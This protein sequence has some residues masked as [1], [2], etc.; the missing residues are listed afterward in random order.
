MTAPAPVL[1]RR[2]GLLDAVFIG[3]GSM[4]GAGV[5]AVW[6]PA[7]QA[8]GPLLLVGLAI[9]LVVAFCNAT[10]SAQL[11]AQYPTSG[12]TYVYGRERLGAWPGFIAGWG[13]VVGKTA[14]IAAMALT[15]GAYVFGPL[16]PWI[17]VVI[18]LLLTGVNL[19]GVTRTA[20][21]TRIIVSVVLVVLAA[22]VVANLLGGPRDFAPD[23][24]A[25]PVQGGIYGLLQSAG[26]LFFAF[27]GYARI[28]TMGEEVK[29]PK[30]VIPLAI[31]WAL[32]LT[33]GVYAA[34][35]AVLLWRFPPEILAV[36]EAPLASAA[37]YSPWEWLTPI[38]A[39]AAAL[40]TVGAML[41][42][43]T[44]VGR[45][46]LAMARNNDLPRWLSRVDRT[47]GVPR[48]AE[49][50]LAA[51]VCGLVLLTDVRVVIGFSSFGVLVYY[52]IANLAAFTQ[53]RA[54]RRYPRF[55][56]ILGAFA[57]CALVVT[58]PWQALG[59]GVAVYFVGVVY[60]LIRRPDRAPAR[61]LVDTDLPEADEPKPRR[62]AD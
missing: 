52:L 17:A 1:A 48:N 26:L 61:A 4:I 14:A 40:A 36:T 6:A 23:Q 53:Q 24:P 55:L 2:L 22:G 3:L 28:A 29:N 33:A 60:R 56:Q 8:A 47:Y 9:A 18:V 43:M 42:L 46:T 10:S 20:R 49:L 27:A 21:L 37:A 62:A 39:A 59:L 25:I 50:V 31:L 30:R 12:G 38:V 44:G 32:L 54:D 16:A 45:T 51:V 15:F 34:V 41:N 35:G 13:F 11:A 57:C 19:L 5:F 58:L 7:A